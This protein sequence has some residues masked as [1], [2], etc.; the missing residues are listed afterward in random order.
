MEVETPCQDEVCLTKYSM[1]M[2][3]YLNDSCTKRKDEFEKN[4]QGYGCSAICMAFIDFSAKSIDHNE[5]TSTLLFSCPVRWS[6]SA[7]TF[8]YRL[9]RT[10][11]TKAKRKK[12]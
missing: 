10:W 9:S 1:A 12:W 2:F 11:K 4:E 5:P 8:P 3:E 6:R 7:V